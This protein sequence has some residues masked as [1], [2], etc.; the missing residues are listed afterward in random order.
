MESPVFPQVAVGNSW[1][2]SNNY[3]DGSEPLVVSQGCQAPILIARDTLGFVS[4]CGRGIGKHLELRRNFQP[5]FPV[6][7]WIL[8][9]V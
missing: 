5:P 6:A 2:P 8:Y 1:F 9:I 7:T 4:S 3:G